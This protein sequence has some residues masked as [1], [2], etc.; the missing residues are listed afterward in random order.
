M[1]STRVRTRFLL[2][3]GRRPRRPSSR[4]TTPTTMMNIVING[5]TWM[6]FLMKQ[7]TPTAIKA[8]AKRLPPG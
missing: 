7:R 2:T 4:A 5:V 6:M 1:A 3:A 8:E